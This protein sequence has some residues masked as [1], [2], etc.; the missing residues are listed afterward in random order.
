MQRKYIAFL[1]LVAIISFL[2][3]TG[4]IEQLHRRIEF[5]TTKHKV[6]EEELNYAYSMLSDDEKRL[7][8]EF[9][10]DNHAFL[11]TVFTRKE[12]TRYNR[13]L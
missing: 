5:L 9:F 13:P 8:T 11:T 4:S 7:V 2:Y 3:F 1:V 12:I 10:L 6:T